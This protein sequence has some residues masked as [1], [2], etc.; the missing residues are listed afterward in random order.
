[1]NSK[2]NTVHKL[3]MNNNE[4][5]NENEKEEEEDEPFLFNG[6]TLQQ[7]IE[8]I[9]QEIEELN[10]KK[11]MLL[12]KYKDN[13]NYKQINCTTIKDRVKLKLINTTLSQYTQTLKEL[14]AVLNASKTKTSI[15]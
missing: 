13:E 5:E 7:Y 9:Q 14:V 12:D 4:N 2:R 8:K 11:Y 3:E 1:M 10:Q 6:I 15:W